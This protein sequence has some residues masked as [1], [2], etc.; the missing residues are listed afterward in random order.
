MMK[1]YYK[2]CNDVLNNT[3]I[4]N[5]YV[6]LACQRFNRF[7]ERD[8]IEFRE[9]KVDRVI[10][11]ISNLKHY[12]GKS[13]G[14]PF[15]LSDW[16]A[17]IIA[18][19]FGFYQK[20]T[21]KRV[22]KNVYVE[23][24]RKAGKSAL[25]S[26]IALYCLMAD[27]EN[28]SE[29]DCIANSRQQA[30]ILFDMGVKFC[31]TIDSKQ[32]YIKS[33]RDKIKFDATDSYM[34]VLSSDAATL[35]GFNS[36]LFVQ[37]ELHAA[38][39]SKLYDVLKSSQG[40]RENPLAI[41][42][43]SAGFNKFSFCYHM[44]ETCIEIL[45]GKKQDDSQFSII[46]SIDDGDD[47][48]DSKNWIK[49]NPNL[50]ITVTEEY[51]K[52]Q[53]VQAKNNPSLEVSVRTKNFGEWVSSANIWLSNDTLLKNTE[54]VNLD[55]FK[56]CVCYMGVDLAAVSDLTAV[57]LLIPK[58]DKYYF[59]SWYYLPYSALSDNS[60]C[61]LYKDWQ[62]KG[63]LNITDG[64]VTDYDYILS[65]ILKVNQKVLIQKI[66][67]DSYNSTQWAIKATEEGLPLEPFSQALWNFNKPT[68]ELERL[69][70]SNQ[71]IIDNNEIT[72]YC[73][74]NVSLKYDHNDNIK[75]V[76]EEAMQKIDGVISMIQALGAYLSEPHYNNQILAIN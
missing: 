64:N 25:I 74:S 8:D 41:C 39:N 31:K 33:Y 11:F 20:G 1:K 59:K 68:K 47:W 65:D 6:K 27:G 60:N 37:D 61:E 21:N 73:F 32:K 52:E 23:V 75:P 4:T 62:R 67:Y 13:N 17:F 26:A 53:V 42:I 66:A 2:Y 71:V 19:I 72:R 12:T 70:K 69:I 76:K 28:G 50:N 7:I 63:L 46:Y 55:N 57:S 38:P 48:T 54:E 22:T 44:R 14:K 29:V 5:E 9:A 3:I 24:A 45:Y 56:E 34:Q 49:A 10:K 51:L 18:N 30:K 43:T 16:Q 15:I 58:D 35:D 36:Y 40:M